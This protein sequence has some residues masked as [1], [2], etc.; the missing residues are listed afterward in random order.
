MFQRCWFIR[1]YILEIVV[2]SHY[3]HVFINEA[4][5][6][7]LQAYSI[8]INFYSHLAVGECSFWTLSSCVQQHTSFWQCFPYCS[9]KPYLSVELKRHAQALHASDETKSSFSTDSFLNMRTHSRHSCHDR[10]SATYQYNR[11]LCYFIVHSSVSQDHLYLGLWNVHG[12]WPDFQK[13]WQISYP[14]LLLNMIV[15]L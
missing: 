8:S 2:H 3:T 1:R 14:G 5:D 9:P 6:F 15:S 10:I 11:A 7:I 4:P 13:W 12:F